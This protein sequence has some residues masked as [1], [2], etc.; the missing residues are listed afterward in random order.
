MKHLVTLLLASLGGAG[1]YLMMHF[2][3]APHLPVHSVTI[4]KLSGLTPEQARA[5]CD[6]DGLLLVLDAE[7]P[8]ATVPAG[9]LTEQ[10][11]LSG[12][13]VR[14]GSEVHA[15]LARP[16]EVTKVPAVN[17]MTVEAAT[18]LLGQ[19]RLKVGHSVEAPSDT[20]K[21]LVAGTTPPAGSE[22]HIDSAIDLNVSSGAAATIPAITGKGI[23]TAKQLLEKSGFALGKVRY[24]QNDDYDAGIILKQDP[25]PNAAAPI[26][27]KV[28]IVINE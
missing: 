11:P 21:G 16:S 24:S 13:E 27:T 9:T 12:S 7:K 10:K 26:G 23:S 17:G 2:L 4:P 19:A 6:H 25:Q 8:D 28:D 22:V 14:R 15:F 20:P 5:L 3:V 18:A 1:A